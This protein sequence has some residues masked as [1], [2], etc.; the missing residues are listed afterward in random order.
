MAAACASVGLPRSTFYRISQQYSHYRRV[1]SPV[2]HADRHQP[3]ALTGAEKAD[4][5]AVLTDEQYANLSVVQTYWRALDAGKVS[6][7]QRTFYRIARSARFVGDR[8]RRKYNTGK[9]SRRTPIV[10]AGAV[11]ELW[12]WD[13]TELRG[14][15]YQDRYKLYAVMDVFSR[16]PVAWRIEYHEKIDHAVSMFTQAW[17]THGV[18]GTVHADNGSVMR[19]GPLMAALDSAGAFASFSRPRVSDDNPFSE[20]LFKTIKYDLDCPVQFESID[21]AREWTRAFFHRYSTQHRHSGLG[22][23]TPE[24]VHTGTAIQVR[25]QRQLTLDHYYQQHPNRF[26]KPPQAPPLPTATGINTHLSQTG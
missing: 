20:S 19:S 17:A 13:V 3:A 11:G 12:S 22:R 8:R 24:Q 26:R 6:C 23:C 4:V 7:S 9:H 1:P 25:R 16:Y 15:R 10:H 5:L 18:P 14:P 2:P 21:H